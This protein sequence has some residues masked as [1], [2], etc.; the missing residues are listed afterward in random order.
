MKINH[1]IYIKKRYGK[2]LII[3]KM[4]IQLKIIK[5][6]KQCQTKSH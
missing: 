4:G 1:L 5:L 2:Q 6:I 3:L